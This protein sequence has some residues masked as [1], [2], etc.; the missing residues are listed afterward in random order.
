MRPATR[1]QSAL[2]AVLAACLVAGLLS[3]AAGCES[4]NAQDLDETLVALGL[5]DEVPAAPLTIDVEIDA[6][7]GSSGAVRASV[8]STLTVVFETVATRPGSHVRVWRLDPVRAAEL[9]SE[10]E[11]PSREGGGAVS[12]E[13]RA[14]FVGDALAESLALLDPLIEASSAAR[15]S[16]IAESVGRMALADGYDHERHIV[17]VSDGRERAA[18]NLECGSLLPPERFA[19][20]MRARGLLTPGSLTGVH[21]HLA[22]LRMDP[23]RGRGCAA[24]FERESAIRAA[25]TTALEGAGATASITTG[26][27]VIAPPAERN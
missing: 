1:I 3:S 8:S 13:A 5:A 10:V 27:P 18:V 25:W 4:V 20:A 9:V 2:R 7:R 24:T 14:A 6:T 15:R 26:A 19:S 17:L 16:P 12:E 23:I 22:Q 11:A 21:V